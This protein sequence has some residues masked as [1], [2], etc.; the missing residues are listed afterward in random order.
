[1]PLRDVDAKCEAD[2]SWNR[3]NGEI[4]IYELHPS[5]SLACMHSGRVWSLV[6]TAV[7]IFELGC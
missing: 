3:F 6:E 5:I 1:V 4:L 2:V 7:I